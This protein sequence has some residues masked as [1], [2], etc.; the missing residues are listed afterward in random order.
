MDFS[1]MA[2]KAGNISP[3]LGNTNNNPELITMFSGGGAVGAGGDDL[4]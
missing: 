2:G 4:G 3:E 1:T